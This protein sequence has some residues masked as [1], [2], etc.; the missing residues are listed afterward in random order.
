MS[1]LGPPYFMRG[2]S[3][4]PTIISQIIK[5]VKP[6]GQMMEEERGTR[7]KCSTT[8]PS[9]PYFILVVKRGKPAMHAGM[10]YLNINLLHMLYCQ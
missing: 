2:R 8:L 1:L 3:T 10:G 4:Q 5:T 6:T 9:A 7:L